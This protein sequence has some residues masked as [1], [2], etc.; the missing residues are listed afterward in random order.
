[1]FNLEQSIAEWRKQMLVAG[2]KSPVPL[3]ELEIHL[4]EEIER[5]IKS[6]MEVQQ[7]FEM[8]VSQMGQAK[9]LKTEF[10]KGRRLKSLLETEL[11]KKKWDLKWGPVLHFVIFTAVLILF[12]SLV[13]LKQGAFSEMTSLGRTSCLAAVILSYLLFNGG[14]LGY[15]FFPIILG[16]HMRL[17]IYVCGIVLVSVWIMMFLGHV[18][19]NM[20]QFLLEFSWA[21]F[22]PLGAFSGLILGLER[23]AQ[24]KV[25]VAGS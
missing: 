4:R 12:S 13:L 3:E 25:K 2:I 21:F 24:K 11:I 19:V 5:Q 17:A 1:M 6:G 18:N 23:A 14:L 9:E 10:A 22:V 7:A 15:R 16:H 20:P 8:T